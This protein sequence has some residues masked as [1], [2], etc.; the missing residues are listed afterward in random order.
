M[1]KYPIDFNIENTAIYLLT[2]ETTQQNDIRKKIYEKYQAYSDKKYEYFILNLDNLTNLFKKII[3]RELSGKF[4]NAIGFCSQ[5]IDMKNSKCV[6]HNEGGNCYQTYG[7]NIISDINKFEYEP[8][9][10]IIA[11]NHEFAEKIKSN[12]LCINLS[13]YNH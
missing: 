4:P 8:V 9:N 7:I 11:L 2:K 12:K 1:D 10:Y 5:E 6:F 13:R 3:I